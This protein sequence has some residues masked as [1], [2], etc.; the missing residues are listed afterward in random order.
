MTNVIRF[1]VKKKPE[2]AKPVDPNIARLKEGLARLEELRRR[3]K[4]QV[5]ELEKLVK[6]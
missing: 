3:L 6:D 4:T 5:E 1:P 2:P